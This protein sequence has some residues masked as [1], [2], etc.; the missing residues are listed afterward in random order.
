MR[1]K[2]K[3]RRLA[4]RQKGAMSF[5]ARHPQGLEHAVGTVVYSWSQIVLVVEELVQLAQK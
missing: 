2:L 4:N 1:V 5:V 3:N